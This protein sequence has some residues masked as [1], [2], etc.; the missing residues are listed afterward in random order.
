MGVGYVLLSRVNSLASFL[1]VYVLA[2]T[3]GNSLGMS[4]PM[5]AAVANWFNRK[6]GLAFGI[7]VVRRGHWRAGPSRSDVR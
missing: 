6:R 1:L 4:T 5:T 2:I 3:L 7:M